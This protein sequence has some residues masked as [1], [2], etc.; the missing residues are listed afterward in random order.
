MDWILSS[1]MVVLHL[2]SCAN[3]KVILP[4]ASHILEFHGFYLFWKLISCWNLLK[5]KFGPNFLEHELMITSRHIHRCFRSKDFEENPKMK[6]SRGKVYRRLQQ[7][8]TLWHP[9]WKWATHAQ[10]FAPPC[11][12]QHRHCR[13]HY[14]DLKVIAAWAC[15]LARSIE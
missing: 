1:Q 12:L 8:L 7:K 5:I 9:R 15:C 14:H 6:S 13:L 3:W 4:M 10:C 2:V 11:C